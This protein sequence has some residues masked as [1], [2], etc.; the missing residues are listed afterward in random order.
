[1]DI[2]VVIPL[3]NEDE[4]LTELTS[5]IERVMD[6]H[7]FSYEIIMIDDGSNDGSWQKIEELAEKI[8]ISKPSNSGGITE[9][10]LHCTVVFR[11]PREMW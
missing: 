7:H 4:S 1:M 10:P 2:S 3:F 9:N 6:T 5:W 11:R 8:H